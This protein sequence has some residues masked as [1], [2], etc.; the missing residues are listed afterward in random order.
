[1]SAVLD[2]AIDPGLVL[3]DEVIPSGAYWSRAIRRGTTLRLID[4]EGS[5]GVAMLCYNADNPIERY[6]AADTTKI[7]F[8]IVLTRGKLLYS[9]MGRV[10]F[11][12][13]EDTS[14]CHDTLGG[15]STPATNAA[16]YGEGDWKDSRSNFLNA[17][18]KHNLGKKDLM[19]NVNFFVRL[20]V[21]PDGTPQFVEGCTRPGSFV[22][23]RAEMNVLAVLSNCPHP[24]HPGASYD[25]K[26]IR[27]V[28]WKSPPPAA[29]DRCRTGCPEAV[30]GF[31][32][33]DALF[34]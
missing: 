13:T 28:V 26:P 25:P 9:D 2:S 4:P 8:N 19:P 31:V 11:S 6:N 3:W 34:L 14:G 29:D 18:A 22:D 1:M 20:A 33:T 17:L 32:N 21:A 10:L 24:Y 15:M 16:K 30:R 12:I 5:Q 23:L 7:Q 27:A